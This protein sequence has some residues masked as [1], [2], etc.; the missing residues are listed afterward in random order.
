MSVNV[1]EYLSEFYPDEEGII[2]FDGLD[3][4]FIGVGRSFNKPVA[5]YSR[6][7]IIELLM[8]DGMSDLEADEYFEFNIAGSYLGEQTPV[9]IEPCIRSDWYYDITM[10]GL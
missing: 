4:A 3:E 1:K 7:M 9:I 8:S 6:D 2:V 5:C 10:P